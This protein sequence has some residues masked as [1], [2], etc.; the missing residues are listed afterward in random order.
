MMPGKINPV[1]PEFA[2]Q[3]AFRIHGLDTT[4]TMALDA[5][6]LQ[7]NAMLPVA[8]SSLLEAQTLLGSAAQALTDRCIEGIEINEERTRSYVDD[9]LGKTSVLA[10]TLGYE[11]SSAL[12]TEA[13]RAGLPPDRLVEQHSSAVLRGCAGG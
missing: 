4:I 5:A 13:A 9:G 11:A 7:L 1:I 8:A 3:V 6:Q 10:A 12:A 2:N